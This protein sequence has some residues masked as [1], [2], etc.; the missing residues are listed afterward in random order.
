MIRAGLIVVGD[1]VNTAVV[2]NKILEVL[3]KGGQ[4]C[5]IVGDMTLIIEGKVVLLARDHLVDAVGQMIHQILMDAGVSTIGQTVLVNEVRDHAV[6]VVCQLSTTR[7]LIRH[8]IAVAIGLLGDGVEIG[9]DQC[10]DVSLIGQSAN[11]M[12]ELRVHDLSI[13]ASQGELLIEA[14]QLIK[15]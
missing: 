11:G 8:T 10:G 15:A 7:R 3:I 14:L 12:C 1:G 6:E 9:G 4:H 13:N 2:I 5:G